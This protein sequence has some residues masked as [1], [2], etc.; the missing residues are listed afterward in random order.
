MPNSL[1]KEDALAGA[2]AAPHPPGTLVDGTAIPDVLEQ[3]IQVGFTYPVHFTRGL[4]E[5]GNEVLV[6]ALSRREPGRQHRAVVLID[7][8]V[9]A[10]WPDLTGQVTRYFETHSDRVRLL[11][12][13]IILPGGEAAKNSMHVAERTLHCTNGTGID[14]QSFVLAIGGGALLDAAGLGAAISHRGIRLIRIPTTV[15]A[16]NDSGV[17]VKNGINWYEK[18]NFIGTFAPPSRC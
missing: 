4:F 14:R 18:K 11:A 7:D 8:G 6:S 10:A 9:A 2:E 16:Q 1:S 15:L 3:R 5:V 17:G 13:P 12:A